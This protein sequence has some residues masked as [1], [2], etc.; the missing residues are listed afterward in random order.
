MSGYKTMDLEKNKRKKKREK[1]ES[2]IGATQ[3]RSSA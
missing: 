1:K 3:A 2:A